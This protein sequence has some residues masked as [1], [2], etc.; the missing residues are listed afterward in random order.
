MSI[1]KDPPRFGFPSVSEVRLLGLCQQ[2]YTQKE[3]LPPECMAAP[4]E[5]RK[6]ME[7]V[8]LIN[9]LT[10]MVTTVA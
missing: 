4:H 7:T 8:T 3:G 1:Q 6:L 5:Q 10:I 9:A 2:L